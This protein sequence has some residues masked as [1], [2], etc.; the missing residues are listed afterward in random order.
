MGHTSKSSI[1]KNRGDTMIECPECNVQIMKI[2]ENIW[3]CPIC[4][5]KYENDL[6]LTTGIVYMRNVDS[7][8]ADDYNYPKD[9]E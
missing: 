4:A 1:K 9:L 8:D 7:V 5:H 3:E 6:E 2:G